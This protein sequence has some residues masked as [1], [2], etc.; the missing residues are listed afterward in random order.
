MWSGFIGLFDTLVGLGGDWLSNKRIE[1]QEV[2]NQKIEK[3]KQ[4]GDWEKV[5]ATNSGS[6]WKDEFWTIVFAIP[7]VLCFIPDC[8]VYV[9]EGFKVLEETPEWYRYCLLTLVGSS[10]GVRKI[11]QLFKK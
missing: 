5:Q 8:V 2:H 4:E 9:Q 7:L 11:T 10:V 6:S 3:L 1:K